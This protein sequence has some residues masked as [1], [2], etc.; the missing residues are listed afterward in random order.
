MN[1]R[2]SNRDLT[3]EWTAFTE[4]GGRG[5]QRI[6]SLLVVL[7]AAFVASEILATIHDY[8]TEWYFTDAYWIQD[9]AEEIA[10]TGINRIRFLPNSSYGIDILLW[11]HHLPSYLYALAVALLDARIYDLTVIRAFELLLTLIVVAVVFARFLPVRHSLA[12]TALVFLEP[13]FRRNF[14][15]EDFQRWT[16]VFGLLSFLCLIPAEGLRTARRQRSLDYLCGFLGVLAPLCF[17]SLGVPVFAGLTGVFLAEVFTSREAAGSRATRLCAFALGG[18]TPLIGLASYLLVAP[19]IE[20]LRL[21]W[22]CIMQYAPQVTTGASAHR[23]WLAVGYFFAS[24]LVARWGVTLLPV[25]IAATGLSLLGFRQLPPIERFLTRTTAILTG[26]WIGLAAIVPTHFYASRMMWLLPFHLLQIVIVVRLRKT[27]PVAFH[28]FVAT[29]AI[30]LLVQGAYQ[31]LGHPG[32]VYTAAFAIPGML[33]LLLSAAAVYALRSRVELQ[34]RFADWLDRFAAWGV[35][36]LLAL[37]IAQ[38]VVFYADLWRRVTPAL[39]RGEYREPIVRTLAR[40]ILAVAEKELKPG[41]WVLSNASV[42]EFFPE[43][44]ERQEMFVFRRTKGDA[45]IGGARLVPADKAFLLV[46][47]APAP[48]PTELHHYGDQLALGR[49]FYYAGFVYELGRRVKLIPGFELLIGRPV[50]AGDAEDVIYP[51]SYIPEAEINAYLRW[52]Q[53]VGLPVR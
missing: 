42:R 11:T 27:R 52:R 4:S 40:E 34:R 19:G 45:G 49:S 39:L 41:D 8:F 5:F 38:T 23:G 47:E 22:V 36:G 7:L 28:C 30:L 24:L 33:A 18:A 44:V 21:L 16:L 25:G 17:V 51:R 3:A 20:D 35:A 32:G 37:L 46:P 29:S 15:D 43:G 14:V 2:R 12:L 50:P 48:Y 6:I 10:R 31:A 26:T 13:H 1:A 9:S 53:Q